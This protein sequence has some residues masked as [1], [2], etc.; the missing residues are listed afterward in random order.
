LALEGAPLVGVGD[1]G[2][3]HLAALGAAVP[4]TRR[5]LPWLLGAGP[6]L[7]DAC[8]EDEVLAEGVAFE[9]LRQEQVVQARVAFEGDAE[10]LVGLALVP[11]GAGVYGHGRR[12]DGR[13]VRDR[14]TEEKAS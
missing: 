7:G 4:S 13:G 3:E 2:R 9:A 10:H 6:G 14:R 11:A 1:A 5:R 12:E 8:G